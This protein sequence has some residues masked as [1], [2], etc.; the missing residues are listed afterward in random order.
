MVNLSTWEDMAVAFQF[1]ALPRVA[2]KRPPRLVI[3]FGDR[4][5]LAAPPY[6]VL[7][8][9]R[10]NEADVK[11]ARIMAEAGEE[12]F[13]P[14]ADWGSDFS[15]RRPA[16]IA[17]CETP[18]A[19]GPLESLLWVSEVGGKA[20]EARWRSVAQWWG[21]TPNTVD[22]EAAQDFADRVWFVLGE[23]CDAWPQRFRAR[24]RLYFTCLEP[25]IGSLLASAFG[26]QKPLGHSTESMLANRTPEQLLS[27]S[28]EDRY[29]V[30]LG[31]TVMSKNDL[32]Q[33]PHLP[34]SGTTAYIGDIP[35]LAEEPWRLLGDRIRME[36]ERISTRLV[37]RP[38]ERPHS[39]G[40]SYETSDFLALAWWQFRWA[41]DEHLMLRCCENCNHPFL[42]RGTPRVLC[43]RCAT[44]AAYLRRSRKG[45]VRTPKH[46]EATRQEWVQRKMRTRK[47]KYG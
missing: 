16:G 45:T 9:W 12:T 1:E 13:M 15:F 2:G 33:R 8:R 26:Q 32:Q 6:A 39:R 36:L 11:A 42:Y 4:L 25:A 19:G 22:R 38:G 35:A 17:A 41:V 10:P 18:E 40:T 14:T 29:T 30:A 31:F 7:T 47:P 5:F 37:E 27:L 34:L 46:P 44:Q 20:R 24:W 28:R 43:A 3:T 21:I 23:D